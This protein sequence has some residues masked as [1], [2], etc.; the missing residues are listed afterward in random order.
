MPSTE[1]RHFHIPPDASLADPAWLVAVYETFGGKPEEG[2]IGPH[3]KHTDYTQIEAFIAEC[4]RKH[5]FNTGF[6][7]A[8]ARLSE[9]FGRQQVLDALDAP[10]GSDAA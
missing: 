7:T 6:S 8:V 9:V 5:A 1:V 3:T 4:K 10:W 2:V